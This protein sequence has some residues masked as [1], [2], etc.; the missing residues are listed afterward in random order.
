MNNVA[1]SRRSSRKKGCRRNRRNQIGGAGEAYTLGGLVAGAPI[2]NNYGQEIVRFPS[3]EQAVRPGYLTDAQ[4]KGGLPGFSGGRRRKMRGGQ[5]TPGSPYPETYAS[6]TSTYIPPANG[7]S[8]TP[9]PVPGATSTSITPPAMIGGSQSMNIDAQKLLDLLATGSKIGGASNVPRN[10]GAS[11]KNNVPTG[12]V[13]QLGG[14]GG[15]LETGANQLASAGPIGAQVG[16]R[17][18]NEFNVVG[19]SKIALMEPSYSGCGDGLVAQQNPFNKGE[20]SSLITAPPPL[21]PTPSPGSGDMLQK[22]GKRKSRKA[23]KSRK[24]RKSRKARKSRKQQKGGV[25]GVDSMVYNAPR[26][27]YTT[28]PSNAQGGNAGTLADG[29]TPFL[30]NVPFSSQPV[31]SPACLKTGGR[32]RSR[33]ARKTR[34]N[35]KRRA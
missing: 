7:A 19:D 15:V 23:R 33:K 26:A 1:A 2:I 5:G 34:K 25:G 13:M 29:Q 6:E 9:Q 28:W 12:P 24:V 21:V 22:G 17:Y 20:L 14:R 18:T 35:H 11:G 32:R 10:T 31:P 16:G 8:Y 27:G 4:I 30:I 3:C